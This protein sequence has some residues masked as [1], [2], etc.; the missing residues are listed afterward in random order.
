MVS[1]PGVSRARN[2]LSLPDRFRQ[3]VYQVRR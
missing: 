3:R 1:Q 2:R